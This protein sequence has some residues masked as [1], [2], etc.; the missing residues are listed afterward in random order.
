MR[1]LYRAQSGAAAV[2][3]A[4]VLPVFLLFIFGITEV[5]RAIWIQTSLQYAVEAAARC[6]VVDPGSTGCMTSSLVQAFAAARVD[7]LSLPSSTFTI[8][9]P[10]CGYQVSAAYVF[11]SLVPELVPLSV[12][13]RAQSC[14]PTSDLRR[15]LL[16]FVKFAAT[17]GRALI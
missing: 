13:L 16:S 14:R 2:E 10:A 6:G 9:T 5:G 15:L 8:S 12:T 7:G 17:C 1:L 11:K 3:L 4:L